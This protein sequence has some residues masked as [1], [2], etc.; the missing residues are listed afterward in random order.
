MIP[1]AVLSFFKTKLGKASIIALIVIVIVSAFMITLSIKDAAIRS[2]EMQIIKQQENIKRLELEKE[3]IEKELEFVK[4][5]ERLETSYNNSSESIEKVSEETLTRY[6]NEAINSISNDFYNYFNGLS[7]N[8]IRKDT[9]VASA[10]KV[11]Y[12][13]DFRQKRINKSISEE[14]YKNKRMAAL[15]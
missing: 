1:T 6:D 4:E 11:L 8:E 3:S 7:D 12:T 5:L 13:G 9:D 2:K 14:R 15:V 10:E